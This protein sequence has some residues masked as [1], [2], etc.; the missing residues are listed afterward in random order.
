MTHLTYGE[1]QSLRDAGFPQDEESDRGRWINGQKVYGTQHFAPTRCLG[2][3]SLDELLTELGKLTYDG[4]GQ[5]M[6]E[7]WDLQRDGV[8][9]QGWRATDC[10]NHDGIDE[11][12]LAACAAL[13]I[14]LAKEAQQ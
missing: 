11:R 8:W 10:L 1:C 2:D 4:P 5:I 9:V 7:Q 13:Y 12:P 6:L 3:I 14:A